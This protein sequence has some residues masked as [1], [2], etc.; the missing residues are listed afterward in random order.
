MCGESSLIKALELTP[1]PPGNDFLN[2]KEIG[3]QEIK[4]P[5]D[6]YF[7]KNC[8]HVQLSHVVDPKILYQKIIL[9]YLQLQTILLI[10][11]KNM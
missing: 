9:M 1:T 5:L 11:L 8:F 2:Q 6:L 7:C 4:Y 3:K 10:I